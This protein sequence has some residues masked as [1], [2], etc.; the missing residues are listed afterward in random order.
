MLITTDTPNILR[1]P[2]SKA[3]IIDDEKSRTA[4]KRKMEEKRK[5]ERFSSELETLKQTSFEEIKLI[6]QEL[7]NIKSLITSSLIGKV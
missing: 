4:W 7:S 1:D 6:K 5:L 3:I 2:N